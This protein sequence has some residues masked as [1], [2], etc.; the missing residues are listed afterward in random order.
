MDYILA[1]D[2]LWDISL[3]KAPMPLLETAARE[4]QYSVFARR[5]STTQEEV[6]PNV[7]F[8]CLVD[9]NNVTAN[10]MCNS[11]PDNAFEKVYCKEGT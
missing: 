5:P 9:N 8:S 11:G 2:V 1:W 3:V 4:K 7:F 6:G 10:D